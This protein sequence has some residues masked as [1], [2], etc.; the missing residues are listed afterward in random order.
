LIVTWSS[1][2]SVSCSA[3]LS[4]ASVRPS[5]TSRSSRPTTPLVRR[6]RYSGIRPAVSIPGAAF[7]SRSCGSSP[8]QAQAVLVVDPVHL[9]RV[10]SS[11]SSTRTP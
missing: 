8:A 1:K 9:Q 11:N 6:N 5:S 2:D 7:G 3:P 4:N 10:M